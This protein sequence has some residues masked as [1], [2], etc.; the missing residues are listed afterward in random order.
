MSHASDT[1]AKAPCLH[2]GIFY[3]IYRIIGIKKLS[4]GFG[5]GHRGTAEVI[6]I[7]WQ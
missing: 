7:D 5:V 6:K 1:L 3:R 2:P 4:S